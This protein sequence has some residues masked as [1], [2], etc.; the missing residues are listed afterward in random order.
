MKKAI[1]KAHKITDGKKTTGMSIA[2]VLL[3][4]L[5]MYKPDLISHQTE[6]VLELVISSGMVGSLGHKLWKNRKA[7]WKYTKKPIRW[8]KRIK[9]AR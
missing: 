7:I 1:N 5:V 6:N 4:V 3:Q 8:F 2:M 9:K